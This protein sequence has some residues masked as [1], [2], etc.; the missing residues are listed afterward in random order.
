MQPVGQQIEFIGHF[1][2][3]ILPRDLY[4]GIVVARTHIPYAVDEHGGAFP[5]I[6]HEGH[7]DDKAD[8]GQQHGDLEDIALGAA[9]KIGLGCIVIV[10]ID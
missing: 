7:Q 4:A 9:Q 8:D 1:C 10:D 3:L 5:K 6:N 2:Q